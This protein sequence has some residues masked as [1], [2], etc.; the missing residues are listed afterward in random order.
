MQ[1]MSFNRP[2]DERGAVMV[3]VALFLPLL[4]IITSFAI[5]SAHLFDFSRNLQNRADAAAFSAALEYGNTCFNTPTSATGLDAIGHAAQQYSGAPGPTADLPYAYSSGTPY[6]NTVDDPGANASNFHL[7]LN[8]STSAD[9]G[10]VNFEKG[11]FCAA[12]Y[13]SPADPATDVWVTQSHVPLFLPFLNFT[14]NISAHARVQLQGIQQLS[15]N[16]RPIAVRDASFTPCVT[17]NFLDNDGNTIANVKLTKVPNSTLW[18]S[19]ATPTAV[20]PTGGDPV[21][22]QLNLNNCSTSNP[23]STLYNPAG[24]PAGLVYIDNWGTPTAPGANGAPAIAAGGVKLTGAS[25]TNCDPYFE[26]N[27]SG[28]TG[29]GVDA[30]VAFQPGVTLNGPNQ[31][32][33]V[34][35]TVGTQTGI[36]LNYTGTANEWNTLGAASP[37]TFNIAADSGASNVT[38]QWKQT[39]GKVVISGRTRTCTPGNNNPCKGTIP[40]FGSGNVQQRAFAGL[41]GDN[42]CGDEP[43]NDT[44]PVQWLTIGTTDNGGAT[45]GYNAIKGGGTAA[46]LYVTT[47]IEG[48]SNA[49]ASATAAQDICLRLT[50]GNGNGNNGSSHA[51]GLINCGQGNGTPADQAALEN[52]CPNPVQVDTRARAD[53]SLICA[54]AITPQDC[55]QNDPGQSPPILRAFDDRIGSPN[56]SPNNWP[57]VQLSDPRTVIFILVAPTDLSTVHGTADIPIRGFAVFYV[58]GWSTGQGGVKGCSNGTN[59]PAP[60]GGGKGQLWG[61]FTS[62]AV[63]SGSGT[64]NGTGCKTNQLGDCIAVLT[65]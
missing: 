37:N 36:N 29:L 41:D 51:T 6:Q 18:T 5:D 31:N 22:V 38:L 40:G 35:A 45:A 44:G 46:H 61:H 33:F 16:L 39:N 11:N 59:D 56:C 43:N 20:T 24:G 21:T 54:P 28:C 62:I 42:F 47:S 8:G 3:M 10:G 26:T 48:L 55:V 50:Q 27:P 63:P 25:Q 2:K 12:T 4:L 58:T 32:V 14:P 30:N 64:G 19:S 13:D 34:T 57:N 17:A 23:V 9:H 1:V 53:G 7:I 65:R 60:A 52:G 15:N 49:P